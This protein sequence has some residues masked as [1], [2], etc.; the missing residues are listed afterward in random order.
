MIQVIGKMHAIL[1]LLSRS[2]SPISLHELAVAI[3]DSDSTAANIVRTMKDLDYVRHA[4]GRKGYTLGSAMH[5]LIRNHNH[6]TILADAAR[7]YLASLAEDIKESIHLVTDFMGKRVVLLSMQSAAGIRLSE[8]HDAMEDLHSTCTGL[9]LLSAKEDAV[10]RVYLAAVGVRSLA[11]AFD[12]VRSLDD[13]IHALRNVSRTGS[14]IIGGDGKDMYNGAAL[15]A[16]A[17]RSQG[18]IVA[19]LGI[20]MP[21]F[22]FRGN[23]RTAVL[24]KARQTICDIEMMLHAN[25]KEFPL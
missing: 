8:D 4:P 20:K 12:A 25:P 6:G 5:Y 14:L 19:A 9:V 13:G 15:L 7:P 23:N 24:E 2:R 11:W 18:R 17:L 1:T 3:G 21:C 22:R 10:I 16:F